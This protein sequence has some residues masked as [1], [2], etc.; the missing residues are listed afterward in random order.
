[1]DK[2]KLFVDLDGTLAEWKTIDIPTQ[3]PR[4]RI[5][6]II[7]DTLYQEEY[8][9]KLKPNTSLVEA[10]NK[11]IDEGI[12]DVYIL[13]CVLPENEDYPNAHPRQDKDR[14]VDRFFGDKIPK[15][16]RLYVPDGEPKLDS[17]HQ[18]Y[19][20]LVSENDLLLDDYTHN[21]QDWVSHTDKNGQPLRGCKFLNGINDTHKSWQGKRVKNQDHFPNI[22]FDLI[23]KLLQTK[24][25]QEYM[26]GRCQVSF[27]TPDKSRYT[28]QIERSV[29]NKE[30]T[31]YTYS[32]YMTDQRCEEALITEGKLASNAK[33]GLLDAAHT[34]MAGYNFTKILSV[35]HS[36]SKTQLKDMLFLEDIPAGVQNEM[37]GDYEI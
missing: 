2:P 8:Y 27:A 32:I 26:P 21:L 15:D 17:L 9:Y 34:L 24:K 30:H 36:Y 12:A 25:N 35:D 16:H 33:Y 29:V 13:S 11:I 7:N 1:M 3:V 19:G 37:E 10:V 4:E 31:G 6:Q 22:Y 18:I 14:W 20:I 28:L 23:K 5:R